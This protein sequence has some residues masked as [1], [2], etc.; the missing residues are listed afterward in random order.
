MKILTV[1][2]FSCPENIHGC[3]ARLPLSSISEH[4]KHCHFMLI[5]CPA[6]GEKDAHCEWQG[7]KK[8]LL[9][10]VKTHAH[11]ELPANL[12]LFVDSCRLW[13]RKIKCMFLLYADEVFTHY[14]LVL[15]NT[16]YSVMNQ[17]GLTRRQY[18]CTF[19]LD[20][21]NGK[22]HIRVTMPIPE[23]G[24]SSSCSSLSG[25]CFRIPTNVIQHF[26]KDRHINTTIFI[27]DV[28]KTQQKF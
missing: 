14:S 15:D 9:A 21:I 20:G 26:V 28:T 16:W 11:K 7:L 5:T 2:S 3:T 23:T 12:P 25:K 1:A 8:D 22:D 4:H 27:N 19:K 10:H 6:S 17:I 24:D 13:P 18:E